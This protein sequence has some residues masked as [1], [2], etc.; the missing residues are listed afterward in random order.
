MKCESLI[1]TCLL[2]V[3]NGF[4]MTLT[5]YPSSSVEM[6]SHQDIAWKTEVHL[7]LITVNI[8]RNGKM[9]KTLAQTNQEATKYTWIVSNI[10]LGDG[11]NI[12]VIGKSNINGTSYV[13][14]PPFTIKQ[15]MSTI[16]ITIIIVVIVI[17]ICIGVCLGQRRNR[18]RQSIQP[19]SGWPVPYGTAVPVN[20][21]VGS[22]YPSAVYAE[23]SRG[24]NMGSIATGFA[25]GMIFDRILESGGGHHSH[26]DSNGFFSNDGGIDDSTTDFSCGGDDGGFS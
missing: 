5:E 17:L 3:T 18:Y 13:D 4:H 24:S 10:Q 23:Q 16:I 12:R 25:G 21:T 22:Q 1:L 20:P 15:S 6:N 14:S 19:Q 9:I 2:S 11:Y 7:D 26:N 8:N